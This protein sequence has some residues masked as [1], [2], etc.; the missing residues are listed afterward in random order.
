M[1]LLIASLLLSL[2]FAARAQ[3]PADALLGY[4]VK[5]DPGSLVLDFNEKSGAVAGQA[6][7]VFK[8]GEALKHPV[9]GAS[10][11]RLELKVAEGSLKEV[12]PMY[13]IGTLSSTE[14]G[15]AVAPGMRA[16]LKPLAAAAAPAPAPVAAAP[17]APQQP[18]GSLAVSRG[19]LWRGPAFD[20]Q[21]T[22][23]A[24]ADV[25]GDGKLEAAVSDGRTVFLYP[26]PPADA[27]P[28]AEFAARGT[29]P[30][31]LSLDAADLDGDGRAEIFAAL[32]NDSFSR[33]ETRVLKLDA[34]GAL[35]QAAELPS[36]VRGFQDHKGALRLAVQQVTEDP[37][38]PFGAIYPL[39]YRDGKYV[40]GKPALDFGKR[41]ADW[42]YD[43]NFLTLDG[44]PA[45]VDVTTTELLR[46]QFPKG[47]SWKSPESYCQTP[48]RVRW[49][50]D[51][52]LHFRPA[53]AVRYDDKGFAGLFAVKNIASFGGLAGPFGRF[54]R[55]ELHRMDWNGLSLASSWVAELGGYCT[56]LARTA[57]PGRPEELAVLVVSTAGKSSIWGFAP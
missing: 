9:T 23:L 46:V 49:T 15:Q 55:A 43:F 52:M 47:T 57:A 29:S 27:K 19:P 40:A 13:S 53:L 56:A 4:V 21:A 34:Q 45:T 5:A 54:S 36:L 30:R 1:R 10:L 44:K 11:G 42:I 6:F 50:G 33:F 35:T 20:Y 39:V 8:E 48:N 2:P 32:Y 51:R 18:V 41:R 37:S 26:Y 17:L 24:V 3:A 25:N 28:I 16:R 22:A 38:F 7:T 14:A 31:L 12:L